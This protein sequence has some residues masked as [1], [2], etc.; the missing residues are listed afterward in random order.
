VAGHEHRNHRPSAAEVLAAG[1][2]LFA[3]RAKLMG[4]F[5]IAA[6]LLSPVGTLL[7]AGGPN[8]QAPAR[9]WR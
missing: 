3:G 2:A 9:G 8:L 7:I 1:L 5:S 6:G 4:G